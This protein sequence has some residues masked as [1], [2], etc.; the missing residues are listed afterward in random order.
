MGSATVSRVGSVVGVE[1]SATS[2]QN[3]LMMSI[4]FWAAPFRLT[5]TA[6]RRHFGSRESMVS[7]IR[8][9]M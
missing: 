8:C 3:L 5:A 9:A 4:R 7:T 6:A 2:N 1:D